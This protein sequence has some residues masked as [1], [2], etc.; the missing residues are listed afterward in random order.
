MINA[1]AL[2]NNF[3]ED[4]E[5]TDLS[6]PAMRRDQRRRSP[7]LP[8]RCETTP[9]MSLRTGTSK[10]P[11]SAPRAPHTGKEGYAGD[12]TWCGSP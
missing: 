12:G 2:G 9:P 3:R 6:L 5:A 1:R 8:P 11:A 7:A 4:A 10:Q